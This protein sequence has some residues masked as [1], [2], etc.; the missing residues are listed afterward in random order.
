MP[1]QRGDAD[2]AHAENLHQE[3]VS[4]TLPAAEGSCCDWALYLHCRTLAHDKF[5]DAGAKVGRR[6]PVVAPTQTRERIA[7]AGKADAVGGPHLTRRESK[8]PQLAI[9]LGSLFVGEVGGKFRTSRQFR[10]FERAILGGDIRTAYARP[11]NGK[12]SGLVVPH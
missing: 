1:E 3:P 6:I 11:E 5:G 10:K 2:D 7:V 9:G 4:A 8:E 12:L